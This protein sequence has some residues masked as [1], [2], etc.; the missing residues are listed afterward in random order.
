M[1]ESNVK[2]RQ[3]REI[4][5]WPL[6]I[7]PPV[8]QTA[9]AVS[10]K[11]WHAVFKAFLCNP[12]QNQ[13]GQ[14]V[15]L[16]ITDRLN[17]EQGSGISRTHYAE[18]VY[19]HPFVQR[20]LYG[21][22]R[23][24]SEAKMPDDDSIQIY[25]RTGIDRV[26]VMLP[27]AKTIVLV[28]DRIHLYLFENRIALLVVEV[29]LDN[30]DNAFRLQDFEN[31]LDV[32]RRAYPP[33]FETNQ[34]EQLFAGHCPTN[35]SWQKTTTSKTASEPSFR[36]IESA[37]YQ[38]EVVH[39]RSV[40]EHLTA[41][42]SRHWSF[43]LEPLQPYPGNGEV[44]SYQQIE[45]ERMPF[46][47]YIA[48]D[49]PALLTRGDFVRLGFA[50]DSGD[51]DTLPYAKAFLDNFERD[52]CYD[53]YW[54]P[55]GECGHH[56]Y[57]TR[58]ICC[59]YG[60]VMIG[61]DDR[62]SREANGDS[63]LIDAD[64]GMLAHFRHHYFQ[65]GLIVHFHKAALLAMSDR[66]ARVIADYCAHTNPDAAFEQLR[67]D[68]QGIQ[69]LFLKF[70]HRYWFNEVSNQ[71]QARELF[72]LWS[73][74][75]GTEKLFDQVKQEIQD[76]N[77]FLNDLQQDRLSNSANDLGLSANKLATFGLPISL[78]GLLGSWV[79]LKMDT[80]MPGFG[81]TSSLHMRPWLPSLVVLTTVL[82]AFGYFWNKV[83]NA[84]HQISNRSF[85]A[86]LLLTALVF[87]LILFFQHR[88][89]DWLG[90]E[91]ADL[92]CYVSNC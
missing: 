71:L 32:F 83:W 17:R 70:T 87:L 24:E 45:D 56:Y 59:G 36:D 18:F 53:R 52:F 49:K 68:M 9:G 78:A 11:D 10:D 57:K 50:D 79:A 41:P 72:G 51:S 58:Y 37:N 19:F 16:P 28:V 42:V 69:E 23:F 15:W 75:L 33:Y 31:F 86:K 77:G 67:K 13:W 21:Q 20:F 76:A 5:F 48:V 2:V 74:H 7:H 29:S 34:Q 91:F 54:D 44:F 81:V 89:K 73:R 47:A 4:L 40:L 1:L 25:R 64:N 26:S 22:P 38:D 84:W 12:T 88:I 92:F 30:W 62:Q 60:F 80:E 46:M 85:A 63:V 6:Q 3:F 65:M 55:D 61:E 27:N 66:T 8:S 35:V 90:F 39:R 82:V 14:R 43:L